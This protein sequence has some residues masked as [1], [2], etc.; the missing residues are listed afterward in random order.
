MPETG[1]VSAEE[2][3]Y[4]PPIDVRHQ[5]LAERYLVHGNAALAAREAGY[6][7]GG[8]KVTACRILAR[9]EVAE[10]VRVRRLMIHE[11]HGLVPED[12]IRDLKAI[13]GSSVADYRLDDNGMLTPAFGAHPD[14]M[15]A[16][17]RVKRKVRVVP[18]GEG[19]EPE[20][21]IETEYSLWSKPE[22][23][24]LASE[25]L[26]FTGRN[27]YPAAVKAAIATP[28]AHAQGQQTR[29][30]VQVVVVEE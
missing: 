13:A 18:R 4:L 16:V 24:R 1:V 9:I 14:V 12:I 2:V 10:Y 30:T 19:M 11:Q 26:E 27:S 25:M 6:R 8:S 7:G 17:S 3:P 20:R 5:M 15:R 29:L 21:I 22:A 23:L 28:Q